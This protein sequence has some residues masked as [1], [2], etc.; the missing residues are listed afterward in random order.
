VIQSFVVFPF[1]LLLS[2][3]FILPI[4]PLAWGVYWYSSGTAGLTGRRKNGIGIVGEGFI[5][6][7]EGRKEGNHVAYFTDGPNFFRAL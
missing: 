7:E 3:G 6:K 5:K 2:S 1:L 4:S